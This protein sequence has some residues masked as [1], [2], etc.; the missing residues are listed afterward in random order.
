[1]GLVQCESNLLGIAN[2]GGVSVGSGGWNNI[3][4]KY[5]KAKTYCEHPF[6]TRHEGGR[7]IVVPI[8]GEWIGDR[9]NG[10]GSNDRRRVRLHCQSATAADLSQA[11]LDGV[12]TDPPY[13]GNVQYAELMD[14][15]YV[16]IRNLTGKG[17]PAFTPPTTRNVDELT[18]NITMERGLDHFTEGLSAVFRK[19]ARALKP[20]RPLAFTYHHNRFE[21]Y[22][23]VTVEQFA[24]LV[25]MDLDKLRMGGLKPAR[26]DLRC[27]IYGHLVRMTVWNLRE[28]WDA[29][30]SAQEKLAAVGRYVASLPQPD[31]IEAEVSGTEIPARRFA[32]HEEAEPYAGRSEE[33]V[34]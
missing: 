4:E 7:K 1:V 15:C 26:G 5:L 8:K 11:S 17:T 3:V 29:Q 25:S 21:A 13:F 30:R 14:F 12:F 33:V 31:G 20:G 27:V 34:F 9:R 6:E 22:F 18:G 28:K 23:P 32:V 2:G 19:M 24:N 10:K 16:W